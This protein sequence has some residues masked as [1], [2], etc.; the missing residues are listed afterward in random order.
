VRCACVCVCAR[1]LVL[2]LHTQLWGSCTR[3]SH[4][5]CR[6][7]AH[8][9]PPLPTRAQGLCPA[10]PTAAAAP[11]SIA[12]QAPAADTRAR[13]RCGAAA[14]AAAAAVSPSNTEE[15][16]MSRMAEASTMLRT[17][18]RLM[19]LSFGTITPEAS[20][21]TRRTCGHNSATGGR[22]SAGATTAGY[23][24]THPCPGSTTHVAPAVLVA[25][26]CRGITHTQAASRGLSSS[27]AQTKRNASYGRAW[28]VR[29]RGPRGACCSPF[30]WA[31]TTG[32]SGAAGR[33]QGVLGRQ[34][35]VNA[36]LA[37]ADAICAPCT[38]SYAPAL[39]RHGCCGCKGEQPS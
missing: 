15:S 28:G 24:H 10:A 17:M 34:W 39:L 30:L 31:G 8:A 6:V 22:L 26:S 18:N 19:A 35:A 12:R 7:P 3:Q 21:R 4:R 20:Q 5:H 36:R 33:Q 23:T 14:A 27:T 1:V 38:P 13:G 37:A 2:G 32:V 16:W 9:A 11:A 25:S 29:G